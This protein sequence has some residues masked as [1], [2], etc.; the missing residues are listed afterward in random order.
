MKSV[1][2][3]YNIESQNDINIIKNSIAQKNGVI[4]IQISLAKKEL[5]LIYNN[6]FLSIEEVIDSI[7]DLGYIVV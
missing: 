3:I 7:E 6:S 4:A 2:K 1:L 5:T